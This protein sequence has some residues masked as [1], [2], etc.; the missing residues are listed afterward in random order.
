MSNP[1]SSPFKWESDSIINYAFKLLDDRRDE[2]YTRLQAQ[3]IAMH[4]VQG[5][6]GSVAFH[7]KRLGRQKFCWQ[8][9]DCRYWIWEGKDW[10]VF[11][12]NG[13]GTSIEV[14]VGLTIDAAMVVFQEYRK[15][16]GL[17]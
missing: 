9:G 13:H 14:R 12:N 16:V 1:F 4:L 17:Q 7:K 5:K 10:R 3:L 8:G 11:A 15:V 6:E 2:Q